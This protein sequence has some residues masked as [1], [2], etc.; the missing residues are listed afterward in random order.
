MVPMWASSAIVFSSWVGIGVP[1]MNEPICSRGGVS[2]E[3]PLQI[4]W[5]AK[6]A[7]LRTYHDTRLR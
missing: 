6:S 7:P 5:G 3:R 2:I 1:L 4:S